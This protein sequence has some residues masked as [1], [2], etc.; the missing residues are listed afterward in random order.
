MTKTTTHNAFLTMPDSRYSE[1]VGAIWA[2]SGEADDASSEP[3]GAK[4]VGDFRK[5]LK[6]KTILLIED[7][8]LIAMEI[9]FE[10]EDCGA[11]VLGP[12]AR[13][14]EALGSL[15]PDTIDAAILDVNLHGEMVFP[16]A[17]VL[18]RENVPVVFHTG[19]ASS[20]EIQEKYPE[21]VIV[22]KPTSIDGLLE[23]LVSVLP[24]NSR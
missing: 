3:I 15:K 11:N 21:A 19:N 2:M 24:E 18:V 20:L 17:D 13:V 1:Y 6:G 22:K 5:S 4:N 8:V 10:L 7:E 12:I 16:V 9:E 14:Q 23:K